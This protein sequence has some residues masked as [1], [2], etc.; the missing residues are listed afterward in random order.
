[1]IEEWIG[2]IFVHYVF[3]RKEKYDWLIKIIKINNYNKYKSYIKSYK[4]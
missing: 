3:M 2:Q 1:V 4:N